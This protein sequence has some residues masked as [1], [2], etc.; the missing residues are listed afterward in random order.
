MSNV[1]TKKGSVLPLLKLK[2]KDY[3]QVAHRLQWLSD[4]YSNYTI[5]TEFLVLTDDQTVTRSTVVLY[6]ET[7]KVIRSATATK[8]ESKKDFPDHTEKSETGS[9]GRALAMLGLG[10]QMA[11]SDLDEGDRIVDSPV[12][13]IKSEI[14]NLKKE[15]TGGKVADKPVEVVSSQTGEIIVNGV[16]NESE[17]KAVTENTVKKTSF[18]KPKDKPVVTPELESEWS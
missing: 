8:R 13:N 14:N 10:T 17:L 4:D 18:R 16:L 1:M 15:S 6:D 9:V 11:L 5:N 12:T 7:G 2:G 3:L